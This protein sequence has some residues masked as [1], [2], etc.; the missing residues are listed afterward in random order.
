VLRI[1]GPWARDRGEL[2]PEWRFRIQPP[3]EIIRPLIP[4]IA[5][6]SYER[7]GDLTGEER[8]LPQLAPN[9]VFEVRSPDDRW[10]HIEHKIDVYLRAGTDV[11]ILVD[12]DRETLTA[13]DTAGEH[14]YAGDAVFEH[15][16]LPEF[17]CTV[18]DV[19]EVLHRPRPQA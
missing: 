11:V 15:P 3:G 10:R 4:D 17:S 1:L 13:Y 7:L 6:V 12:P 8:E 16:G 18:A 19:F 14:M 2:G 5:F 9:V